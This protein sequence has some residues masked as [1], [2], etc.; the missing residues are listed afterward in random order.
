LMGIVTILVGLVTLLAD[1]LL[2]TRLRGRDRD[3]EGNLGA[4]L[5][6]VGIVLALL[7]PIIAQLIQLAISRSREYIAD[8]TGSG[9]L[10]SGLGLASA[11][12]KLQSH[13]KRFFFPL[14]G[15]TQATAHLFITNPLKGS[16]LMHLLSTH[17][18]THERIRRL[19][20]QTF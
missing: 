2:R 16:G 20:S 9:F 8:A 17:P 19:R 1:I 13:S 5:F 10:H 3:N 18:P 12:E 11:L 15:S 4:I 14:T 7:S 6:V